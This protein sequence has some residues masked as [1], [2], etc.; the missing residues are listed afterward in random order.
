MNKKVYYY[1]I[2]SMDGRI[3]CGT[4]KL[5]QAKKI[6]EEFSNEGICFK[7]LVGDRNYKKFAFMW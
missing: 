1:T 3:Y 2:E 7:R 4:A 5:K 6:C